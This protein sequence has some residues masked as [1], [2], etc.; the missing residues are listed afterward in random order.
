M[1][2]TNKKLVMAIAAIILIATVSKQARASQQ[3]VISLAGQWSFQL[4][5]KKVGAALKTIL[6]MQP[7][8]FVATGD[9]VYYDHPTETAAQTQ[10]Q[11]RKKWHPQFAQPRYIELFAQIPTY[12]EKDD[13]N[14]RYNDC[15]NTGEREPT[16][17]KN[18]SSQVSK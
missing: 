10:Q 16:P 12:W 2:K 13:H 14:Y 6:D 3:D 4:D 7:D 9:N 1:A 17:P 15:N 11:L 5:P 8:F 18:G